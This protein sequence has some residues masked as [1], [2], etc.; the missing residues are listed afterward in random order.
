MARLFERRRWPGPEYHV[1]ATF[2]AP[3]PYVFAWCTDYSPGDAQLEGEGY[4]RMVVQRTR[5]RVVF[6]DLEESP[7]GWDWTRC[8]VELTPPD[9]WHMESTGNRREVVADYQLTELPDRRTQLDLWW[10]RRP[11]LLE[12]TPRSK[13]EGERSGTVGWKHFTRALER[14][15]RKSRPRPRD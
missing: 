10:R 14:D 12:F 11:G 6:E 2:R 13:T 4:R 15:Y 7:R 1:Q 5:R 8:D 9:R 3:R